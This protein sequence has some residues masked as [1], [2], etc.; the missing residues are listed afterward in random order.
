MSALD[1]QVKKAMDLLKTKTRFH[2]SKEEAQAA[3]EAKPVLVTPEQE[4]LLEELVYEQTGGKRIVLCLPESIIEQLVE[5]E[6]RGIDANDF[7]AASVDGTLKM[8]ETIFPDT[9]KESKK[10]KQASSKK[11]QEEM[12]AKRG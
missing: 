10:N 1:P 6:K 9:T 12:L 11:K 7:V 5:L 2:D 3:A 4:A 8:M